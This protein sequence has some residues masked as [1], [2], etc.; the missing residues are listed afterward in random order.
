MNMW[1]LLFGVVWGLGSTVAE[2]I[3]QKCPNV[4]TYVT[5]E[6]AVVLNLQPVYISFF[7]STNTV[8]KLGGT[9]ISI[10]NAPT[11]FVTE[12]T[13]TNTSVS[14]YSS[15][16]L[17]LYFFSSY[18]YPLAQAIPPWIRMVLCSLQFLA[19]GRRLTVGP[20]PETH[21]RLLLE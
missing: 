7:Q 12:I 14:T 5:I 17:I 11:T 21:R 16:V 9:E 8:F 20:S 15:Y 18:S 3:N 2:V 4:I 10:T 6:R 19:Q 13:L 1:T